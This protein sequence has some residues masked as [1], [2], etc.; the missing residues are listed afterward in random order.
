MSHASQMDD[1]ARRRWLRQVLTLAASLGVTAT[2]GVAH[3]QRGAL[4]AV[5]VPG[6]PLQRIAY[7]SC[8][9]QARD[10]PMW[11]P[12]LAY[13]PDLFIFGGDNV[14]ASGKPWSLQKL[15][16]AYAQLASHA[17]FRQLRETV[18]HL[19]IWDDHDYGLNDGGADFAHK[20]ESRQA[21]LDFWDVAASDPR[22]Q[23]DGVYHA[24]TFGPEGRRVQVILLDV[25]SFRSPWKPT[26][27]R[28]AP[29]RERYLPDD[30]PDRQ[31][32]GEAQWQW[33]AQQL[34]EPAQVRL[35]VSGIQ[36]I[37]EGHG[38]EGW[39]LFPRER[40]RLMRTVR[41][42]RAS[43]VVI[44]SGD[45]HVGALYRSDSDAPYP[46]YELTSSGMTHPWQDASEAGPNRLGPLVTELHFGSVDVDWDR[47]ELTL[48]L[49]SRQGTLLQSRRVSLDEL[50]AR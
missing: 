27:R 49:R 38:W 34:R 20:A 23:R 43:G 12:V 36:V 48:G 26:D 2:A 3:A 29:G 1:W 17:G 7:G 18:P 50:R 35:I 28:D 11:S 16:A 39:Q 22:R 19:A 5:P 24:Q 13:G 30:A 8:I 37:V 45:R 40:A 31:M 6:K 47:G 10:Q 41:E 44:L 32:L 4:R 25:R 14:Y 9:D 15:N 33:L 46:M 42:A 21:F